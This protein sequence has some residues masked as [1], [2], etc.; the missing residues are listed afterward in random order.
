MLEAEAPFTSLNSDNSHSRTSE[1]TSTWINS[2]ASSSALHRDVLLQIDG[3][4]SSSNGLGREFDADDSQ[5]SS[6]SSTSSSP[7]STRSSLSA[8]Y[9][10]LMAHAPN[11]KSFQ[12]NPGGAAELGNSF[13][14]SSAYWL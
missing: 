5:L 9:E 14:D 4:S 10:W 3:S 11:R 7:V 12:A 2:M 6:S 1:S 8:N 13:W